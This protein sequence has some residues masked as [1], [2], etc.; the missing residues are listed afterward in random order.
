MKRISKKDMF[1]HA[2]SMS[3]KPCL[4]VI[5]WRS[6]VVFLLKSTSSMKV[7]KLKSI[8]GYHVVINYRLIVMKI[9]KT[10]SA[11]KVAQFLVAQS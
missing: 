4:V 2:N 9:Q 1:H 8:K 5:K 6:T 3:K 7:V 10:I 11:K